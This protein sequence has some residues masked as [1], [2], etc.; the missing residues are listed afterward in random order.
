M[1]GDWIDEAACAGTD[2]ALFDGATIE[3]RFAAKSICEGCPVM[4]LCK[5][6]ALQRGF[7]LRAQEQVRAG[8][9]WDSNGRAKKIEKP[10]PVIAAVPGME[11]ECDGHRGSRHRWMTGACRGEGC[12]QVKRLYEAA[13]YARRRAL[14]QAA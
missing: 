5:A 7:G 12:E 11:I 6:D 1:I 14:R 2:P 3:D 9:W 10:E 13:Y 8:L 4:A